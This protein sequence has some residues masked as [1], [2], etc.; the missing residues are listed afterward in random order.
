MNIRKPTKE[1]LI[2]KTKI[3]ILTKTNSW[4]V[5]KREKTLRY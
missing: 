3:L 5:S 4:E 2:A 1:D